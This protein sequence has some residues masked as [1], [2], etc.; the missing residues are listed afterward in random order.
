MKISK[1]VRFEQ[2]YQPNLCNLHLQNEQLTT[3]ERYS[4]IGP[5]KQILGHK[6]SISK[7][8]RTEIIESMLSD[9]FRIKRIINKK[10]FEKSSH[11]FRN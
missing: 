1:F 4:Y 2:Q 6:L 10:I 3:T 7:Y 8:Q 5:N 11:I 9:N